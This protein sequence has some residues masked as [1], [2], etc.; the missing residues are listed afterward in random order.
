[1]KVWL[2]F[3]HGPRIVSAAFCVAI[4]LAAACSMPTLETASCTAARSA[5]RE[6][7]SFHFANEL[8]LNHENLQKRERF[9]SPDLVEKLRQTPEGTDPFTV[10]EPPFPR[11]FRVG[12]CREIDAGHVEFDVLVFWRDEASTEQRKIKA[13]VIDLEGRWLVHRVSY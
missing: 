2:S 12:S 11:A 7:Y 8:E 1:M 13:E 9:L 10:G 4:C 6:F 3:D 5:A